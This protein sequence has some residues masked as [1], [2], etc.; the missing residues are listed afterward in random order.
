MKAFLDKL[1]LFVINKRSSNS[2][3]SRSLKLR[4]RAS[5]IVEIIA[6]EKKN[7]IETCAIATRVPNGK[8]E[9]SKLHF[10]NG[11]NKT[12]IYNAA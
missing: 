5:A 8:S 11:S 1:L 7:R 2:I 12:N 10:I 3:D 6:E 9:V 4:N